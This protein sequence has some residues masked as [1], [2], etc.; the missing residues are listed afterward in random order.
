MIA[1]CHPNRKH[2]GLNLCQSCYQYKRRFSDPYLLQKARGAINSSTIKKRYGITLEERE[3]LKAKQ[4]FCCAICGQKK[5]LY[6]D[7]EH[8][9]K[10]VRG[11][12]CPRCNTLCGFLENDKGEIQKAKEYLA[13]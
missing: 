10:N 11:M 8:G 2:Y 1:H 6:I 9:T 5:R 4:N 7:H 13:K 12:L 3:A